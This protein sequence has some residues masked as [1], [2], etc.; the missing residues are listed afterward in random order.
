[1]NTAELF[2]K[3]E[4]EVLSPFAFLTAETKGRRLS[5]APSP[6][7]T[8]FQRDRDRIIHCKSFRRLMHKTQVFFAPMDEQFRTRMTHTLEVTQIARSI[9]RA[10]RLNE[11]LTEAIAMGHD[12]GHTPFGHAGEEAMRLCF[13]PAFAHYEQSL[14]VIDFLEKNG[15]GLNL[16]YEVRDGI[17]NHTG[18]HMASTLEG[19]VVK[20]ADRIAYINHDL[21]DAFFAGIL[22]KNDIPRP[23]APFFAGEYSDRVDTMVNAVIEASVDQP[24]IG[25]TSEI[26]EAMEEMRRFLFTHVYK[27][28][29]AKTEEKKAVEL[30]CRLYEYYAAHP[31]EMPPFYRDHLETEGVSRMVCDYISGMTDQYAIATYRTLFIP[32][33]WKGKKHD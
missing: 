16:T 2:L 23:L 5:S 9:A 11:D 15:K 8:E 12:L 25:M 13:D 1:M 18:E 32:E 10:L 29:P 14:R 28:S 22:S 19:V 17:V 24:E 26:G 30:L 27:N 3:R 33:V 31:E 4:K 21:D 20:Y 6:Y 7:R